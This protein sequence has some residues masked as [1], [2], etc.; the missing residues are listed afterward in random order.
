VRKHLND[1]LFSPLSWLLTIFIIGLIVLVLMFLTPYGVKTVAFMADSSLKELSI[2]G[3]S[4]SLLTGLH[5]DEIIWDE[6]G[7]SISLSDVDLKL[8][9]YNTSR[10]RLVAEKVRAGRLNINLSNTASGDITSLP[11]F[12]LP[13]NINAHL[14]QLDSLQITQDVLGDEGSRTLLFQIKD[15]ELKKVTVSDGK[16]RFRK[17]SGKPIILDQPL[18][19]NVTEGKLNMDYP[20]DISTSGNVDYKHPD[21]GNLDGN[22]ELAGTLTN[23]NFKGNVNHQ[24]KDLGLQTIRFMG[25]GDYKRIHLEQVTLDGAHGVVEAKGRVVFDPEVR[26]AFKVDGKDLSTKKFLADWPATVD[27]DLRYIGSYID[28]RVENNIHITSVKGKLREYDLKLQG[29]FTE[30]EG[31]LNTEG[32]DIELGDNHLHVSGKG[33]EPYN[34][35]WDID[36]K[37]IKQL[38]P[39]QLADLDIA[40]SVKGSGTLKG[41]LTKPEISLKVV[42]NDLIYDDFKQGKESL[43]LEGDLALDGT[44][45]QLKNFKLESGK[46]K[47]VVSGQASEPFDVKWKID[48]KS[49][50]QIS[51]QLVGSI[52]G[53]GSL[54]GTLK[55]PEIKVKVATNRLAYKDIKQ[56]K[57]TLF[58][59]GDVGIKRTDKGDIIQLKEVSLKSGVNSL[60]ASG[61][62]SEPFDLKW[63]V[64]ANSLKQISP[65][66]GSLLAKD[67]SGEIA[68]NG[69]LKG[70]LKKPEVKIKLTVNNLVY[71]GIK[72]GKEALFVEGDLGFNRV[73][74]KDII[75]LKGLNLKS[76]SNT[77]Q[78]SGQASEPLKLDIKINAQK[79]AEISP[80]INGS[81]KGTAQVLGSFKS[82]IIKADLQASN[83]RYKKDRLGESEIRVKGEVQLVDGIPI[84]K[85]MTTYV[86]KNKILISGRAT[87]PFDMTW[88]IEAQKLNQLY[89]GLSGFLV[90][91]GKLQGTIDKPIINGTGEA[92]NISYKD[93]K[94]GLG[95]VTAQTNNGVYKIKGK[96][97]KLQSA[98]Q[99][100]NQATFDVNGR[101]ENHSINAFI[102]HDE[103]KVK[104]TA[105][106]AWLNETWRG[107]L[108]K[109]E[110][111]DTQAGDWR[112]QKP[113]QISLSKKGFSS[114][115][116]C[117]SGRVAKEKTQI[118]SATSWSQLSGLTTNGSLQKT[119][120][121]LFKPWLPE[122]LNL[123]GSVS[124]RYNIEQNN[125]KP[126]GKLKLTLPNSNF[127]FKGEDGE[128]Q[129]FGY[130]DAEISAVINDRKI[131][132]KSKMSIVNRGKLIADA[133]IKLSPENG[134]HTINGTA[135][136]DIPNINWAQ[137][138]IPRSRGLRGALTSE[139]SFSGLL[140]KPQIK[141]KL[142]V[143]NAYL[144]LPEAGTE[145]TNINL[146]VRADKPGK[147]VITGKMLM[148][149]GVLNVSGNLDVK[150]IT[151]WKATIKVV[152]NNILFMNTNEIKARMSPDLTIGVTPK[153]V[154]FTG[155]VL[156]PEATIKL[157]KIPEVSIDEADDA[158]VIGE[159]KPGEQVSAI[160]I[161]PNVLVEL[162][163]KVRF[164]A[165]GLDAKLSGSINVTHNR[166]DILAN[167]SLRVS[168]GK[169]EAYGQDLAIDNG[170][171][172]FNGSPKQIGVDVRAT[173]KVDDAVVG[174]HLG[175]TLLSPKSTIYSDPTLPE[176]EALSFLLTGHSLSTSSGTE[177]ALLMSAVRGLGITG[178][179]SLIHNIGSALGLDDVNIVT[180]QDLNQSKL[181]LGK[182]LGSRLYVEYFF[183]LFDQTQKI[184]IK[185]KINKVLSLEAQTSSDN[186]YGL[187]FIYE[188]ERD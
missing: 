112:L 114:K 12:G 67:L 121:S 62:A 115:R 55:A 122:G 43:K 144:R 100:I 81:V 101:I 106:G 163:D 24:Q 46:N 155:K 71:D 84:I 42:A 186:N 73:A 10:G 75:Q 78:V 26:W 116:F 139:L 2:K 30:K 94:L 13:L 44:T 59:D 160:K 126:K 21:F 135:K 54:K 141:G 149:K 28:G 7:D 169:Y 137:E 162:G 20:H 93:F 120:L 164:D 69:S 65:L 27:A 140:N 45:L 36:A 168:D 32:L 53:N 183:G 177:S 86:G 16:L 153:V 148:G 77:L 4:G 61:Q 129:V 158:F 166:R 66:L 80:D 182:Q 131:K 170:R 142:D 159:R 68:G 89:P 103:G 8:Q 133:T 110:L 145:L 171:L 154:S 82:P 143:K 15:I 188:I 105:N 102:D 185:Y 104:L 40:G 60:Q 125:G 180:G 109:L 48:A 87:S 3:L 123:N 56:G 184:S 88:D 14:L 132:V 175:G 83:L 127:S 187:D 25:E 1:Y 58:I 97:K 118:C 108:Q 91:K 174:I 72:Q 9:H 178:N 23:Y 33:N 156:I 92:K 63:K 64:D 22:I 150:D 151:K 99:K 38:L 57:E 39:K 70:T 19:I 49:L 50:K 17:L 37:N 31:S 173:R 90:A 41:K 34:L 96:A 134:K 136:F 179:N 95:S 35:K 5:I 79:L 147:A 51:P 11:N 47:V 161:Q 128:E 167:G 85:S 74:G 157:K 18:N 98:D 113:T 146:K 172:I 152:G 165:F 117:L 176:S 76:G 6:E 130:K 29:Q 107:N 119:P 124:G 181:Q 111:K 52:K 138:F